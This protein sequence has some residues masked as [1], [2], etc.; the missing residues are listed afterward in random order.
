MCFSLYI[1]RAARPSVR[2]CAAPSRRPPLML[3]LAAYCAARA[4]A[5][6][7]APAC[8]MHAAARHQSKRVV[9]ESYTPEPETA[10]V[11]GHWPRLCCALGLFAAALLARRHG[12]QAIAI[13]I[14]GDRAIL[15][16]SGLEYT[17]SPPPPSQALEYQVRSA[18][19]SRS[20]PVATL[21]NESLL[22]WK[23]SRR[24][25]V[26]AAYREKRG[27]GRSQVSSAERCCIPVGGCHHAIGTSRCYFEKTQT[28]PNLSKLRRRRTT[29]SPSRRG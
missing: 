2:A 27:P 6:A 10:W 13:E 1:H 21:L 25:G 7:H 22:L 26:E 18:V 28:H 29:R 19:G 8:I 9:R 3:V 4:P 11:P 16:A 23:D 14:D 20:A 24:T 15:C 5:C 12:A 17:C